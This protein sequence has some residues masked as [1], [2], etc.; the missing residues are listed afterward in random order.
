[1]NTEVQDLYDRVTLADASYASL[2][3]YVNGN[4][5]IFRAL[6]KRGFAKPEAEALY[7]RVTSIYE[8]AYGKN[9]GT[10]QLMYRKL[11]QLRMDRARTQQGGF[12]SM[13]APMPNSVMGVW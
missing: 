3:T 2:E 8:N 9:S 12:V 6:A 7:Q 1:M 5:E 13:T 4:S 11:D 10:V